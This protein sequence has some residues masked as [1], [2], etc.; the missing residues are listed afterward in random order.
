MPV[1]KL[2]YVIV[3]HLTPKRLESI[4]AVLA[5]RA[6]VKDAAPLQVGLL[7]TLGF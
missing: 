5:A 6:G 1:D 7:R 2:K 3:T 4:K